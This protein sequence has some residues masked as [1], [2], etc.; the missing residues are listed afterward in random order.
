[1]NEINSKQTNKVKYMWLVNKTKN[2]I[3]TVIIYIQL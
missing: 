1:M 2:T 3:I